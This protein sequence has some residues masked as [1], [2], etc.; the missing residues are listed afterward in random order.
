MSSSELAVETNLTI[1]FLTVSSFSKGAGLN[2]SGSKDFCLRYLVHQRPTPGKEG[3][4]I[5]KGK[6]K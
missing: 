3:L 6:S 1:L 2:V 4:Q 5:Q